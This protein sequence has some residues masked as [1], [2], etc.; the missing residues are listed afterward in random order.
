MHEDVGQRPARVQL[1]DGAFA[2]GAM[3]DLEAAPQPADDAVGLAAS[4]SP[5]GIGL[6]SD[7]ILALGVSNPVG[8]FSS[9]TLAGPE[10]NHSLPSQSRIGLGCSRKASFLSCIYCT[11]VEMWW[12]RPRRTAERDLLRVSLLAEAV[13]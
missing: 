5:D 12:Q 10:S 8:I 6:G 2:V 11:M 3:L 4:R 9:Q 7:K 1:G 13:V